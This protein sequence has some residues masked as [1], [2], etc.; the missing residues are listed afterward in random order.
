[1]ADAVI[2]VDIEIKGLRELDQ[3]IRALPDAMQT[4][5]VR[6]GLQAAGQ[7]LVDGMAQ[8]A[9]KDPKHRVMRRGSAFPFPLFQSIG[10]RVSF[11]KNQARA[12]VGPLSRAFWGRF[13][14]LGTRYQ[15]PQ[16]FMTP[17]LKADGERAIAAFAATARE[18]LD[19]AARKLNPKGA[20]A[21]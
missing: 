17:T 18:K 3:A 19:Q 12:L 16:P 7:V 20:Q 13:Q 2:E 21:A 14:E 5:V 6:A 9:P 8:R 4:Q 10:M 11:A 1:V 15:V